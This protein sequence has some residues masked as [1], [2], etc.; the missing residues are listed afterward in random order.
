MQRE[1]ERTRTE[2]L[3]VLIGNGLDAATALNVASELER[4]QRRRLERQL[5]EAKIASVVQD[6]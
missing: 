4:L 5:R 1:I 2:L 3:E 6:T